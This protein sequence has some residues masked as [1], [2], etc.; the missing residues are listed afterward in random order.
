MDAKRMGEIALI[1]LRHR[2]RKEGMQLQPSAMK[3]RIGNL[4]KETEIPKE[5]L[6]EFA[7]ILATEL[8][9]EAFGSAPQ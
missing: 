5:E 4:H 8:F 7:R 2:F 1:L 9:Q 6:E 3:R